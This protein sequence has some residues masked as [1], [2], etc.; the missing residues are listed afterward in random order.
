MYASAGR[1]HLGIQRENDRMK[2]KLNSDEVGILLF[3]SAVI[4]GGVFRILPPFL[5]DIPIGDGGLFYK[6]IEEVQNNQFRLP[7][8]IEYNE[9]EIPFAYPPL[10]FYLAGAIS[11]WLDISILTMMRWMPSIVLVITLPFI[12]LL[13]KFLS[14]STLQAG[15]T[16]F[17]YALLPRSLTWF[18][19]GGG[20]TRSLGNLFLVLALTQIYLMLAKGHIKYILGAILFSSLVCLSHP[21]AAIHTIFIAIILW[22]FFGRNGKGF[23]NGAIVGGA[24]LLFTSPW[25]I[26]VLSRFGITPYL[27]AGKTG[28]HSPTSLINI[29]MSFSEE[30][31]LTLIA[32]FAIIGMFIKIAQREYFYPLWYIMP[33]IV[34]PRNAPNVSI[35]PMSILAGFALTDLIIPGISKLDSRNQNDFPSPLGSPTAR[36]FLIYTV[37]AAI[38]GMLVFDAALYG[39]RISSDMQSAFRWVKENTENGAEF[40]VIT[41]DPRLFDDYVNEWFPLL[42]DRRSHTTIQGYEWITGVDFS[43]RMGLI[44]DL[45]E[46]ARDIKPLNCL[47]DSAEQL[48]P[49]YDYLIVTKQYSRIDN[50]TIELLGSD[51]FIM[52]YNTHELAIFSK[53][54]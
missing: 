48:A 7:D 50:L 52:I 14:N 4:L 2:K 43:E 5:S 45:Q 25:W 42:T 15:V 20:V 11:T 22:F 28:F 16:V 53:L 46:C 37:I 19:M 54:K 12:F 47:N 9:I 29:F 3:L 39:K 26:T 31:L 17:I 23:R 41:G 6:M 35:I 51:D 36:F 21:E 13:V 30:P 24:T 49:D 27:T 40:L 44:A 18:I 33:F 34:E 32:V 10:A 8:F 38:F 1:I